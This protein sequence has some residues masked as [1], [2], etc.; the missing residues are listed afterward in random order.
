MARSTLNVMFGRMGYSGL[1][2]PHGIRATVSTILNER[3][4]RGDLIERQLAHVERNGARAA[5]NHAKYLE[6][7]RQMLQAWSDILDQMRDT[8]P[9]KERRNEG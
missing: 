7:R 5:Y 1:L 9:T 4:Y 2:T 3:G 8:P 6:E